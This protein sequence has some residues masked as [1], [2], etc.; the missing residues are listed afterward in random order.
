DE[1][2]QD[3][4]AQEA[5]SQEEAEP[6]TAA[7]VGSTVL[8]RLC[9]SQAELPSDPQ[10]DRDAFV[11]LGQEKRRSSAVVM[12]QAALAE[13]M[14]EEQLREAYRALSWTWK[15][16]G[17]PADSLL[18][19]GLFNR[20]VEIAD[21]GNGDQA[22]YSC[23][24]LTLLRC[25]SDRRSQEVLYR[26]LLPDFFNRMEMRRELHRIED[27]RRQRGRGPRRNVCN[28]SVLLSRPIDPEDVG[29]LAVHMLSIDERSFEELVDRGVFTADPGRVEAFLAWGSGV[30]GTQ[31]FETAGD[32]MDHLRT[33]Y[34]GDKRRFT[35]MLRRGA[36]SSSAVEAAAQTLEY[37]SSRFLRLMLPEEQERFQQLE[38]CCRDLKNLRRGGFPGFRAYEEGLL[39]GFQTVDELLTGIRRTPTQEAVEMLLDTGILVAVH[40]EIIQSLDTLYQDASYLPEL[41][42]DVDHEEL[43]P[44][45]DDVIFLVRNGQRGNTNRQSADQ[46]TVHLEVMAGLND[47]SLVHDHDLPERRL[48][49][50]Q[51]H[52][53]S[54][55]VHFNHN[56]L[57]GDSFTLAAS[58]EYSYTCGFDGEAKKRQRRGEPQFFTFQ[59]LRQEAAVKDPE[60]VNYY[61]V[62]AHGEALT[63]S[64]DDVKMFFG[65][66]KE[67]EEIWN[68]IVDEDQGLKP[69]RAIILYGQKKCGKT[70]LVNQ[71]VKRIQETP[72]TDSQ[73]IIIFF[74][75]ISA[76]CGGL[77]H[78]R[79]NFYMNIL[80]QFRYAL[81][82]K[83][84][85]V[86]EL[87]YDSGLEF[88]DLLADGCAPAAPALFQRFFREFARLDGGRHRVVLV[89]DEFTR[90]CTDIV[91]ALDADPGY[92]DIPNFIKMLSGMGF[93]Q[94]VIGHANMVRALSELGIINHTAE[95][96]K[97][98]E[99]T[100]LDEEGARKLVQEP[101]ERSFGRPGRPADI[102]QSYSGQRAVERLL[103]L[104]GR[105]PRLLMKLCNEMFLYYLRSDR[106]RIMERD[107]DKMLE[108]FLKNLD[109]NEFDM[110]LSEDGDDIGA[111]NGLATFKYLKYAA[112]VSYHTNNRDCDV[113][114]QCPE[115]SEEE[116]QEVR[117]V[118]LERRVISVRNAR[119]HI[120]AGLFVE[121]IHDRYGSN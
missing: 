103:E 98:V 16:H 7:L 38:K 47:E 65:R 17:D 30:D 2:V 57:E 1:S 108:E 41:L 106:S 3:E 84:P 86:E 82:D 53:A 77:E 18:R 15:D 93:I 26:L 12:A 81:S 19:Q 90:L 43:S 56:D 79:L 59:I 23:F 50:G 37:I 36:S 10:Q 76:N 66:E 21:D 96:A 9:L 62:P 89:M 45:E 102:Y 25:A 60:A 4:P 111:L 20:S 71:I 78:F 6:E 11:R 119:I 115:L 14:P 8:G 117:E 52:P 49:A 39:D 13:R 87:L 121:F 99:L 85:D 32:L 72:A 100:A 107:V 112:Q 54:L 51:E 58:V 27:A 73:A 110:L 64:D 44:G 114:L 109:V 94:I 113:D 68:Y 42:C 70:S 104:S 120:N 22:E 116:N 83:H 105:S 35:E 91:G 46:I 67:K 69:G 95:F 48:A 75:D 101:M 97:R 61:A 34:R 92:K 55:S 40:S 31:S 29:R 24:L 74:S 33:L 118:L 80:D 5:W 63:S 28:L 88:P